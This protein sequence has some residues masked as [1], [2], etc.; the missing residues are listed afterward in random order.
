MSAGRARFGD[1]QAFGQ[2]LLLTRSGLELAGQSAPIPG[3]PDD[4]T[5]ALAALGVK[6]TAPRPERLVEGDAATTAVPG[7]VIEFDLTK[8][9][10]MLEDVPLNDLVSQIQAL[11]LNVPIK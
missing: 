3:L 6:V 4:A 2:D 11:D 1:G 8:L 10:T 9:R 5:A 7:L